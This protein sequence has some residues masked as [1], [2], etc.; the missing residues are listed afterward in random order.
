MY[1]PYPPTNPAPP[2]PVRGPGKPVIRVDD[3]RAVVS[4]GIKRDKTKADWQPGDIYVPADNWKELQPDAV[5][6]TIKQ[7]CDGAPGTYE[8]PPDLARRAV[9]CAQ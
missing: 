4:W 3:D 2:A 7:G 5:K 1:S 6:E 8:C 9:W